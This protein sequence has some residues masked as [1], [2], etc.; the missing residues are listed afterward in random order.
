MDKKDEIKSFV[1]KRP[2][3]IAVYAY[4]SAVF[5]Q[6]CNSG[7]FQTDIIFVV[8]DIKAWHD[9]NMYCNGKDYSFLGKLYLSREN[10]KRIKGRN[11]ITY[12]S[13]VRDGNLV[14]KY[15]VVEFDDLRRSLDTWD[16]LFLVGRFHKPVLNILESD[17]LDSK[18]NKNR[19]VAFRIACLL[20]DRVTTK[21][22][23]FKLLCS[24][25]YMG[26]ARMNFAENPNKVNNIV[27]GSF[28]YFEKIYSFDEPYIKIVGEQVFINYDILLNEIEMLP[29]CLVD[30][31]AECDTDLSDLSD[32]RKNI[33]TFIIGHNKRESRYQILDGFKTNG[34]VRSVPYVLSKL[35]KRKDS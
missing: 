17:F 29:E 2:D 34:I 12:F 1:E 4:G 8:D 32:V 20:S 3:A 23:I 13:G 19:D 21:I 15:G 35:R 25:S 27:N 16:N 6:D 22:N 26:D 31:L 18:I 14:Y 11:C 33:L 9:E 7:P 24:L 28:D 30:Y 10:L 5:K